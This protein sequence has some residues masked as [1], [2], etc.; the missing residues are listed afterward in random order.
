MADMTNEAGDADAGLE[1]GEHDL[2][3]RNGDHAGQ[4]NVKRGVVEQRDTEQG[5]CKE[6]EL[7]RDAR[8]RRATG[9]HSRQSQAGQRQT[10]QLA[11]MAHATLQ[12]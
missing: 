12:N 5:Q 4:G 10:D 9:S 2:V 7:D 3:Q 11:K 8:H 1:A 6:D